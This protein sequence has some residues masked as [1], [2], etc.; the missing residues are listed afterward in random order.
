MINRLSFLLLFV[1]VLAFSQSK[2][3]TIA[4]D[5]GYR[6]YD[7]RVG[8]AMSTDPVKNKD[9]NPYNFVKQDTIKEWITHLD[10][11]NRFSI[12]HP[13]HWI[14]STSKKTPNQIFF[15]HEPPSDSLEVLT[16]I[17]IKITP[18]FDISL[19]LRSELKENEWKH[20]KN[21]KNIIILSKKEIQFNK[22]TAHEY[23]CQANVSSIQV[24][25][26]MILLI[27]YKNFIEISVT[28]SAEKYKKNI[29]IIEKIIN[30]F[31][32]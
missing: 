13:N 29:R 6:M 11:E 17:Q 27:H 5:Y 4:Y 3:S 14:F 21:Y 10:K 24:K 20:S 19:E 16:N 31:S 12:K 7:A 2:D 26:K 8:K 30:S 15:I 18:H 25:W 1:P 22:T 28:S 23:I 32:L 9:N